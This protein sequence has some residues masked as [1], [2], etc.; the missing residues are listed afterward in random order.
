MTEIERLWAEHLAVDFPPLR[1]PE[2]QGIDLLLLDA[3]I[4][5]YITTFLDNRGRL[6]AARRASL[7]ALARQART[8][9]QALTGRARDHFARLA[10]VADLVVRSPNPG[11]LS[12]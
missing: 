9:A 10:T 3:D 4:A 7:D 5:E 6:P 8:A 1:A 12:G 11:A 2:V